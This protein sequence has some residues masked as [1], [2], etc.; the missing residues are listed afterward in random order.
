MRGQGEALVLVPGMGADHNSWLRQLPAFSRHYRVVTYDPRGLGRSSGTTEPYPFRALADDVAALMD[1]L[2][3]DKAHVLGQSLGG[4]VAQEVAISHPGRVLKLVLVST[5][6][7]G[8]EAGLDPALDEALGAGRAAA[9]PG[10]SGA[11]ARNTMDALI[12]SSFNRWTYRTALQL[13]CRLFVGEKMLAGL[14]DQEGAAAECHT[15]DRLHLIQAPTLV[16]TGTDDHVIRPCA[17]ELLAARI[18]GA[19]LVMVRGG[20]HGF[21]LEM[22]SRFNRE[23]LGF[24]RRTE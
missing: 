17:S 9:G 6:A 14:P 15:I 19:K 24:L 2:G 23:V 7:G 8:D 16:I 22:A 20:S 4:L 1:S 11:G 13:L 3:I 10:A 5:L 12:A 21:N 18:P